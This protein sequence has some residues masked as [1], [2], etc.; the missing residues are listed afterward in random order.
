MRLLINLLLVIF[1]ITFLR[2]II[3]LI[4]KAVGQMFQPSAPEK[5]TGT[6]GASPAGGELKPCAT[7]GVYTSAATAVRKKVG[8]AE[9]LFCSEGC[10][11]RFSG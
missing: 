3:G 2:A 4:G 5:A 6:K 9:K 7:C 11:D 10:R 1:L 8:G